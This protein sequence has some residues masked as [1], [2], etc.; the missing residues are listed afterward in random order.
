MIK[1]TRRAKRRPS[2]RKSAAYRKAVW[3]L[4]RGYPQAFVAQKVGVHRNSIVNWSRFMP[5]ADVRTISRLANRISDLPAA[6]RWR[7]LAKLQRGAAASATETLEAQM[8][9]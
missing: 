7:L 2:I 3:Y 5:I 1:R 9:A 6:Y 8:T 4:S